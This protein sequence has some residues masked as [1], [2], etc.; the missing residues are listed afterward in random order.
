MIEGVL[1]SDVCPK[2]MITPTSHAMLR[3]YRHYQNRI[4]PF[5]GGLLEQPHYFIRAM[6]IIEGA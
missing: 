6:D 4:L 2:P 1:E 5:G 3:L